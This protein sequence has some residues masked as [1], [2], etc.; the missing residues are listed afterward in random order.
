MTSDTVS[1]TYQGVNGVSCGGSTGQLCQI[2]NARGNT[3]T[4]SYTSQTLGLPRVTGITDR[5]G[6]STTI[7]YHDTAN[8]PYVDT[9]TGTHRTEYASID[10]TGRVGEVDQGDTSS[11]WRR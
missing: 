2:T 1:S 8:P 11:N 9:D 4:F 6:T 3:T 10:T 7:T 5:R